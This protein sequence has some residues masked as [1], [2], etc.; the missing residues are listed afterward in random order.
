MS[1]EE[2]VSE[3]DRRFAEERS[4]RDT[5]SAL[6]Y[7]K[8]LIQII[9]AVSDLAVTALLTLAGAMK[10]QTTFT[11]YVALPS[12]GYVSGIVC[13]SMNGLSRPKAEVPRP[14]AF[15]PQP[16]QSEVRRQ[17][18]RFFSVVSRTRKRRPQPVS[19]TSTYPWL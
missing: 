11:T 1:E 15:R 5:A 12:I 16:M 13:G 18:N 14:P 9:V 6:E 19:V 2:P 3:P 7:T 4:H 17:R 8:L 10:D